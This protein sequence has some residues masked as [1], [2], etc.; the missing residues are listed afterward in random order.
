MKRNVL[1]Q[2]SILGLLGLLIFYGLL[3]YARTTIPIHPLSYNAKSSPITATSSPYTRIKAILNNPVSI[4]VPVPISLPVIS[5]TTA[6]ST[7]ATS[8]PSTTASSTDTTAT[9]TT[10]I[11]ATSTSGSLNVDTVSTS[12]QALN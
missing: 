5:T 3:F 11:T 1:I 2:N 9:S 10:P 7:T 12:T 4:L 8:T 6:T